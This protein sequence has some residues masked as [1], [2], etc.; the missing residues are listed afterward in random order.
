MGSGL[1]SLAA[2]CREH[3]WFLEHVELENN[4][5]CAQGVALGGPLKG[6]DTVSL[7]SGIWD[8]GIS[9]PH[10]QK[11][12]G[13]HSHNPI[14]IS[15]CLQMF[16]IWCNREWS[17]VKWYLSCKVLSIPSTCILVI[18]FLL[19]NHRVKSRTWRAASAS[20]SDC[21]DFLQQCRTHHT[22]CFHRSSLYSHP[23]INRPD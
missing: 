8:L 18:V 15:T 12:L 7:G 20:H 22:R 6:P 14:I 11:F 10:K 2:D 5:S 3:I 13:G 9:Q 4:F 23:L 21:S 17:T 1:S 19:L 16:R